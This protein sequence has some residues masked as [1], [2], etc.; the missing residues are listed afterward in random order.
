MEGYVILLDLYANQGRLR[1]EDA[2][3]LLLLQA[4]RDLELLKA[5]HVEADRLGE[6]AVSVARARETHAR[7]AMSEQGRKQARPSSSNGEKAVIEEGRGC[8]WLF[9]SRAQETRIHT[10]TGRW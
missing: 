9:V 6:R 7:P 5:D 1:L 8:V 4:G 10:G 2:E 3:L